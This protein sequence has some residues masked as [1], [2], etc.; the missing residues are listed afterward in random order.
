VVSSCIVA[1]VI[2]I[3]AVA[4][5]DDACS[6][7]PRRVEQGSISLPDCRAYELV[8]PVEKD[9]G[10]PKAIQVGSFE[11]GLEAIAGPRASSTGDRMAWVSEYPLP[12]SAAPFLQYL[13][14]RGASGWSSENV[15]PPQSVENGTGCPYTLGIAAWS[16]D[17]ST[18]V[19]ADGYAQSGSFKGEG[20]NCGH[21]EPRLVRGEP[22]GFQNLFVRDNEARSYQLVNVTPPT[23]PP[24]ALHHPNTNLY[25]PA[26]FLAGSS[27]LSHVVF[28]EELPLTPEAG[29]GDELYEWVGGVV[30]LVSILPGGAPVTEARLA[31]ATRNVQ[32]DE[33]VEP[34]LF[35]AKN[36]ADYRHAVSADGRSVFFTAEGGLYLRENAEQPHQEECAGPSKACTVQVDS[37]QPGATGPSGGGDFMAASADGSRVFFTDES[38]LT[39]GAKAQA[40]KP[41]LYEYN[42][43][44]P[45]GERLT[46]LTAGAGEPAGVLGISGA[47]EDGSYVYFVAEAVLATQPNSQGVTAEPGQPNLYVAHAGSTSFIAVL[48]RTADLCVWTS[49]TGCE[50]R[51]PGQSGSTARVSTNGAFLAFASPNR[52][53][54]Y[55]NTDANTGKPDSEIYRYDAISGELSC[56]SCDPSGAAPTASTIIRYPAAPSLDDEMSNS[57]PQRNVSDSG[58]VFFET[59]EALLPRDTNGARDVY[60]YDE[61]GLH[62]LSGGT[63]GSGSYFLD[64]TP[65]GGD[66][67]FAT[68]Q[69]LLPRDTDTVYDYYD[70]RVGGGF[71]EPPPP[72]PICEAE[73]CSASPAAPAF[74]APASTT[75]TGLGNVSSPI[76]AKPAAKPKTKPVKCKRAYVNRKHKCVKRHTKPKAKVKKSAKGRK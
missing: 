22:E 69:S 16:S 52:L 34:G 19:L 62:L 49:N 9:N 54:S 70:A 51:P 26:A 12:G 5:A 4:S 47:A 61:A 6:N 66:V 71:S 14:T 37:A 74:S 15:I 75:F 44:M 2:V 42:V 27:D 56:A 59:N 8:T 11:P 57:Y 46:D 65:N 29:I 53:T 28:E 45:L 63:A 32:F 17:L 38:G 33:T 36:I 30:H 10:E 50:G 31:G 64:A 40:G 68:A 13:S 41:D 76:P 1:I 21:D 18:G 72:P 3:P 25:F 23:A 7:E 35:L 55:D 24:P 73:G 39:A 20:L 67:F 60:E 48:D 58:Q 43:E